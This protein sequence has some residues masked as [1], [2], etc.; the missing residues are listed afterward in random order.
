MQQLFQEI[1]YAQENKGHFTQTL[2]PEPAADSP[3]SQPA[4]S[5]HNS[6]SP[7]A[8]CDQYL[9]GCLLPSLPIQ[10]DQS[11]KAGQTH[12]LKGFPKT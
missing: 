10:W 11:Q 3:G 8:K 9:P 6:Q 7:G 5:L 4:N 1:E 2:W 12:T